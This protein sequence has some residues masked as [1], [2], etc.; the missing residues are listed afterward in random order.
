MVNFGIFILKEIGWI[1]SINEH[2]L[3]LW[4]KYLVKFSNNF[5]TDN[6]EQSTGNPF[7]KYVI[8]EVNS[9]E[10]FN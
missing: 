10:E 6:M 9:C 4:S 3:I 2:T 5:W 8:K 7:G 1:W